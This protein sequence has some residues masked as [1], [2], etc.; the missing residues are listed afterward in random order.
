M[1]RAVRPRLR[2]SRLHCGAVIAVADRVVFGESS[3]VSVR[4]RGE[5]NGRRGEGVGELARR[6]APL[7]GHV[8]LLSETIAASIEAE[9]VAG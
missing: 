7:A 2:R 9:R 1:R 3:S 6:I 5:R 8:A 4:P